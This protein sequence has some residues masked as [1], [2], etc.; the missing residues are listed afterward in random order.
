MAVRFPDPSLARSRFAGVPQLLCRPGATCAPVEW[1]CLATPPRGCKQLCGL[2]RCLFSFRSGSFVVS[3]AAV[4]SV[5]AAGALVV[6]LAFTWF[7]RV[8]I[9]R[10]SVPLRKVQTATSAKP[11][12]LALSKSAPSPL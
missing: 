9:V 2:L 3:V 1:L 6:I 7:L 5:F 8:V 10:S 4:A 12:G 11:C